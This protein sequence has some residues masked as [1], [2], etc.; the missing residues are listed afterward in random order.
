MT[1]LPMQ[2]ART[3]ASRQ[4]PQ[5][6]QAPLPRHSALTRH[7]ALARHS[8]PL[9]PLAHI[10]RQAAAPYLLPLAPN[11]HIQQQQRCAHDPCSWIK[12]SKT[13]CK[14]KMCRSP[15]LDAGGCRIHFW[16][17]DEWCAQAPPPVNPLHAAH[18]EDD[19]NRRYPPSTLPSAG[20]QSR[21]I[22]C[23][24]HRHPSTILDRATGWP[25]NVC[26][27]VVPA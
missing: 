1:A 12:V 15:C 13:N 17:E 21:R 6:R 3:F 22:P 8:S 23:A 2:M 18:E 26:P 19:F 11:T 7:S 20:A 4:A 24:A 5:P 27:H 25:I 14:N 10:A 9:R 16:T